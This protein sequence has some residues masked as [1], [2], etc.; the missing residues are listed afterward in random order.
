MGQ[1][2]PRIRLSIDPAA[3]WQVDVKTEPRG[4]APGA[5]YTSY[6]GRVM[7]DDLGLPALVAL[8]HFPKWVRAAGAALGVTFSIDDADIDVGRHKKASTHLR[9]WLRS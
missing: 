2:G 4:D 1:V 6:S 9:E 7:Q 8:D 5:S 3:E